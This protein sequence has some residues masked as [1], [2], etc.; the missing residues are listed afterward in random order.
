M[1]PKVAVLEKLVRDTS[2]AAVLIPST[3]E[4]KEVA[5]PARGAARQR[6]AH[7]RRRASSADGTATQVVFAGSTIVKSKV[8]RGMPLVT[9]RPSSVTPTPAPTTPA[10]DAGRRST[11]GDAATSSPG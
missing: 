8:T 5:G 2:P 4:G 3:Q 11:L 9:V 1:T 6:R 10:V 7:R